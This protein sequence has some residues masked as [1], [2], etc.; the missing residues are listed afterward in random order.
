VA[1]FETLEED[2]TVCESERDAELVREWLFDI[3][4][5]RS[6]KSAA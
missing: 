6:I 3:E 5:V 2:E 1:L 4:K